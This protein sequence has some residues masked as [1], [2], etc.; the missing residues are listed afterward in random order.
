[1]LGDCEIVS[2][3]PTRRW[4]DDRPPGGRG[5]R[6]ATDRR[7]YRQTK[8][9]ARHVDFAADRDFPMLSA[10]CDFV[11]DGDAHSMWTGSQSDYVRY[12]D[13]MKTDDYKTFFEQES[14]S[15]IQPSITFTY[16]E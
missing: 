15:H 3:A 14:P 1:V 10:F 5:V 8:Y 4:L 9:R 13:F 6:R 2:S 12:E 11:E 16:A 7:C